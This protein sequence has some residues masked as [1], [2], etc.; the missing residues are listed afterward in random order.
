LLLGI[1][2]TINGLMTCNTHSIG[3]IVTPSINVGGTIELTTHTSVRG[4]L[5]QYYTSSVA[6]DLYDVSQSLSGSQIYAMMRHL[7][8]G[9]RQMADRSSLGTV[10]KTHRMC[11]HSL[12]LHFSRM[13]IVAVHRIANERGCQHGGRTESCID[14]G[15]HMA[16]AAGEGR[17]RMQDGM[18]AGERPLTSR[19]AC[20]MNVPRSHR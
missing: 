6:R 17:I 18:A 4:L 9:M 16:S 7:S 5:L 14:A 20:P 10:T 8:M 19:C 12:A 1:D 2:A 15:H 11:G 13:R 3:T